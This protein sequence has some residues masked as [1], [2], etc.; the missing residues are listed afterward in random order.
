SEGVDQLLDP[1]A[2]PRVAELS[3]E[4]EV[5]P[6][7]RVVDPERRAE[8][9]AGD[10]GVPLSLEGFE[11]AEVQADPADHRLGGQLLARMLATRVPH[12]VVGSQSRKGCFPGK[13]R[14]TL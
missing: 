10:R 11:L 2:D 13:T 6:D 12:G 8:L 14:A 5:L 1:V 3:E 9:A 7:L 4:R